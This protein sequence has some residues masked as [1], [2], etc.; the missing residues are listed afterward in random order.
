[1]TLIYIM[2]PMC[3]WCYAFH[4]QLTT[5]ISKLKPEIKVLCYMGGLAVDSQDPMPENMQQAIQHS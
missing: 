3:S 1:M 4:P 5:L 2:D